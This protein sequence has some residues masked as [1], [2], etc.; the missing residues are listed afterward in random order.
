M[1]MKTLRNSSYYL[2]F[3]FKDFTNGRRN[4]GDKGHG[5]GGSL[6]LLTG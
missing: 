2:E 6:F 4:L 1:R 5:E 3:H